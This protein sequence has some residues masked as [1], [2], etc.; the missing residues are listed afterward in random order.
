MAHELKFTLE[1]ASNLTKADLFGKSDPYCIIKVNGK[2]QGQSNVVKKSLDPSWGEDFVVAFDDFSHDMTQTIITLEVYDHD[3]VG[4]HDFLGKAEVRDEGFQKFI[5]SATTTT[6][7]GL[8][9]KDGKKSVKGDISFKFISLE[10]KVAIPSPGAAEKSFFSFSMRVVGAKGLRSADLMGGSDAYAKVKLGDNELGKTPVLKNNLNPTWDAN[11]STNLDPE[12]GALGK[13]DIVVDIFDHDRFDSHDFLGRVHLR[14]IELLKFFLTRQ[15]LTYDLVDL[16]KNTKKK[17]K[18]TGTATLQ[19]ICFLDTKG[20]DILNVPELVKSL[21]A[22]IEE[23]E[24]AK[25]SSDAAQKKDGPQSKAAAKRTFVSQWPQWAR[26]YDCKSHSFFFLN[27]FSGEVVFREP[28]DYGVKYRTEERVWDA[29]T[30]FVNCQAAWKIQQLVRLRIAK[31]RVRKTRG[32]ATVVSVNQVWTAPFDPQ[33]A[34]YYYYNTLTEAVVWR[35]PVEMTSFMNRWIEG[36]DPKKNVKYYFNSVEKTFV[37]EMPKNYTPGGSNTKFRASIKVQ[38]AFRGFLSRCSRVEKLLLRGIEQDSTDL[39]ANTLREAVKQM[40]PMYRHRFTRKSALVRSQ[41][42]DLRID[43]EKVKSNSYL[44]RAPGV[45][46]EILS[47]YREQIERFSKH[48]FGAVPSIATEDADQFRVARARL[49]DLLSLDVYR[50]QTRGL[51]TDNELIEIREEIDKAKLLVGNLQNA[52]PNMKR[53]L[54]RKREIIFE[55]TYTMFRTL[56]SKAIS[57]VYKALDITKVFLAASGATKDLRVAQVELLRMRTEE[58][59]QRSTMLII[60]RRAKKRAEHEAFVAMCQAKWQIGQTRR[61][62]EQAE[63]KIRQEK[64]Q[65]ENAKRKMQKESERY[66]RVV[67]T[68]RDTVSPWAVIKTNVPLEIFRDLV[69]G[70]MERKTYQE[71]KT[72]SINDKCPDTGESFV[73][74]AT[75]YGKPDIVEYLMQVRANPNLVENTLSKCTPL[76]IAAGSDQAACTAILVNYGANICSKDSYGDNP[77]HIACRNGYFRVVRELVNVNPDDYFWRMLG[78]PNNKGKLPIDLTNKREI[79]NM[80]AQYMKKASERAALSPEERALVGK[81]AAK[82]RAR[83]SYRAMKTSSSPKPTDTDRFGL[84]PRSNQENEEDSGLMESEKL[85][86]KLKALK[87]K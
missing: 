29:P 43:L 86:K 56:V 3:M 81:R 80:L 82:I 71:R 64:E 75:L 1:S 25:V 20:E 4:A 16:P 8:L 66:E 67:Q 22:S 33:L 30:P 59:K 76:H 78:T 15:A 5:N 55:G 45:G 68:A 36:Y 39:S 27:N 85:A 72:F 37:Y 14:G 19:C 21:K 51:E 10:K 48:V 38:A 49:R 53:L 40:I 46:E 41:L 79:K 62:D 7:L 18:V 42:L 31:N 34:A 9:S 73:G 13:K 61:I 84:S 70:E 52:N 50:L 28:F 44:A 74:N 47:A 57:Q 26:M 32:N 83:N 65:I 54:N 12:I 11:F 63:E 24:L 87:R 17:S 35:R 69:R 6:T 77:L 23:V 2:E 60:K 58:A